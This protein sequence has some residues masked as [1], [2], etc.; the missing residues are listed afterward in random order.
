MMWP[1]ESNGS[2]GSHSHAGVPRFGGVRA[3]R[4]ACQPLAQPFADAAAALA[5]AHDVRM[6]IG[7]A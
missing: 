7:C 6:P 2:T 5:V 1:R 3:I 4:C